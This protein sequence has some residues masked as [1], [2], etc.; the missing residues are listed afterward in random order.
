V[1]NLKVG[2]EYVLRWEKFGVLRGRYLSIEPKHRLEF[3]WAW[4]DDPERLQQVSLLFQS[5]GESGTAL[6][7]THGPCSADSPGQNL[8]RHHL[9]GW[10]KHTSDLDRAGAAGA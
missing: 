9:Q 3:T 10:R 8:R 7:L 4:D 2:G 6:E 1:L 5:D